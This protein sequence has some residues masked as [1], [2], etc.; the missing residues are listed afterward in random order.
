MYYESLAVKTATIEGMTTTT[1]ELDLHHVLEVSVAAAREAG[2]LLL[3]G[4]GQAKNIASKSSAVD[5]VTQFDT[6][7]E[8]LLGTRLR[9][10]FPDHNFVGEE[11][12]AAQGT[13]PYTWYI[14]P[15]DGTTNFAHDF[16]FFCVSLALWESDKPLMGVI[17]DPIMDE[18]F[19]AITGQGAHV[20]TVSGPRPLVVTT[21]TSLIRSLLATGFPYD[22]HSSSDDNLNY[23]ATFTKAAQGLRRA[24]SAAL[25]MVYVAAGRLD[26]Y[27]ELKV[28][29]WDVA[30]AIVILQEAGG[31]VTTLDGQPITLARQFN[32]VSSNGRIHQ[33]MLDVIA[34]TPRAS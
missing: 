28:H 19:T 24:G 31:R 18:C 3:A 11:G 30:A 17:Y 20:T 4:F 15:L 12:L 22:V 34:A 9:G 29:V 26:G 6:A 10:A 16:P 8:E 32:V 2:A 5:W 14:D 23:T 1:T 33:Q 21:E 27:W 13:L 25:D 7:A